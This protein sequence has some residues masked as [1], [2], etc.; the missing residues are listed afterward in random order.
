MKKKFAILFSIMLII[1]LSACGQNN[2][3]ENKT[4]SKGKSGSEDP[5]IASLSIH[6]TND[7]LALGVTPVGSVVGGELK[8]FLPHVKDKLKGTKKLGSVTDPDMEALLALEPSEIYLD[9]EYS[10]K[11]VDK[12]KKIAPTHVFNLN[13][14]TWRDHLKSVG[15]LVDREKEAGQFISDYE[16]ETKEVKGLIQ[17]KLGKDSKVMAI[18]VT[19]KELRVFGTKR[20]MGPILFQDLGLKP[21]NGVEKIDKNQPYQVISQEVLPDFDA[22]AIFVIVNRDDQSQTA[23]KQ[24]EKTAIWKG[25]KA[26]KGKHVYV[27]PDQPWLDYSALGNKMAMDNAKEIFSK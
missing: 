18:R 3:T 5:K 17:K 26:V 15:K 19:A 23:F 7:L 2:S 11:N 16:K 8:D 9:E 21:A 27:I 13:D 22:D 12:F 24:L 10:G 4:T 14:G 25:L 20:P 6:L 1:V